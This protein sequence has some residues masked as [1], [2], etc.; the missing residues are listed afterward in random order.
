VSRYAAAV[1]VWASLEAQWEHTGRPAIAPGGA[2]GSAP[3]PHPLLAQ[4]ALARRE[5]ATLG[6]LLGMDPM[7][8]MKLSRH[9]GAGRP[10]GAAS[11][12]DRTGG[13]PRRRLRAVEGGGEG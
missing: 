12:A 5:A 4:I 3:V 2:T 7:G 10:P 11:A 8:R 6:S 9:I 1:G 13:P